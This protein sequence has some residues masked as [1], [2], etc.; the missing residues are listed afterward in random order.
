MQYD[1]NITIITII[2]KICAVNPQTIH[3]VNLFLTHE[4]HVQKMQW[5]STWLQNI[6]SLLTYFTCR[7]LYGDNECFLIAS[8]FTISLLL[9]LC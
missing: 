6:N 2:L 1:P 7:W 4:I 3:S 9:F 5:K 8:V